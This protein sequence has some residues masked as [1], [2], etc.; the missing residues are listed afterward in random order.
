MI[1]QADKP[2]GSAISGNHHET[3]TC[4][5]HDFITEVSNIKKIHLCNKPPVARIKN[6]DNKFKREYF[7]HPIKLQIYIQ[8][9]IYLSHIKNIKFHIKR[10]Y[11]QKIS[12]PRAL[13]PFLQYLFVYL[14]P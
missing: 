1:A 4:N 5:Q 6:T 2:L 10:C 7:V 13:S 8:K 12:S 3:C 9:Y 14:S 11:I